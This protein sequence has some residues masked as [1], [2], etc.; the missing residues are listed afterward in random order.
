M[1]NE[2][3]AVACFAELCSV[4]SNWTP[5]LLSRNILNI[6]NF[7]SNSFILTIMI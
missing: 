2:A 4:D 1:E 6:V 7:P 5:V 3:N